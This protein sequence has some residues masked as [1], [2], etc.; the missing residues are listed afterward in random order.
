MK[1]VI[2]FGF[3]FAF[4]A[5]AADNVRTIKGDRCSLT[6]D[7]GDL[8][9]TVK[10]QGNKSFAQFEIPAKALPLREGTALNL[11]RHPYESGM[12]YANGW[13]QYWRKDKTNFQDTQVL[14]IQIDSHLNAPKKLKITEGILYFPLHVERCN[15]DR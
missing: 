5:F 3:L 8:L 6:V 2:T 11:S 7:A 13:L 1:A 9:V 12:K 4:A 14:W 15:F 10:M